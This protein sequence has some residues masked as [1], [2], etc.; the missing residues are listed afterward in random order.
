MFD[1]LNALKQNPLCHG[2]SEDGLRIIQAAT[3][4]RQ[5]GAGAPIFVEKMHGESAFLLAQGSVQLFLS[6]PQ[7]ERIMAVLNAPA[8][9]GELSLIVPGA[10]RISARAMA[11]SIALEIPRRDFTALQRQRPQACM[12]FMV[13]IMQSFGQRT[14]MVAPLLETLVT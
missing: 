12:K 11:P 8:S 9:F 2:F 4:T 5:Y 1:A 6:R 10:R 7:G 14:Q 13:N 3:T